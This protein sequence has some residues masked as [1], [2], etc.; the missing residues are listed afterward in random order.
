MST[1]SSSSF[2]FASHF[3]FLIVILRELKWMCCCC[4]RFYSQDSCTLYVLWIQRRM[5]IYV[6]DDGKKKKWKKLLQVTKWK[7]NWQRNF[8]P[9][10]HFPSCS[11]SEVYNFYPHVNRKKR[12]FSR[13][14]VS[15]LFVQLLATCTYVFI[16]I[17]SLL[18]CCVLWKSQ[19]VKQMK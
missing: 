5:K 2:F 17:F 7:R 6:G 8:F 4:C 18:I 12:S 11:C 16:I 13:W 14:F 3:H 15:Y 1:S 19:F 9:C 10:H